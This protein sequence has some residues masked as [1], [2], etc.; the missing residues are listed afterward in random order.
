M[1]DRKNPVYLRLMIIV[2]ALFLG[3]SLNMFQ[4]RNP[5]RNLGM[6]PP[7]SSQ[8][9]EPTK[10]V[11]G[12][13]PQPQGPTE[14]QTLPSASEEGAAPKTAQQAAPGDGATPKPEPA[15]E[16]G[17]ASKSGGESPADQTASPALSAPDD[18]AQAAAP[19]AVQPAVETARDNGLTQPAVTS[20]EKKV[21]SAKLGRQVPADAK[22][23]DAAETANAQAE[24]PAAAQPQPKETAKSAAK[25][26][27]ASGQS[28]QAQFTAPKQADQPAGGGE[29]SAVSAGGKVLDIKVQDNPSEFVLTIVTDAPLERVTSFHA[30]APARL[31]VD[32]W[33]PWQ[34]SGGGA[35][36]VQNGLMEKVRL[37]AHPDKLRVVIDY[38]DKDLATFSEPV[39][40]KQPKG[41]VV[42]VPKPKTAAQ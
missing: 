6:E 11:A 36:T 38:R 27:Q 22:G 29:K 15:R 24:A 37:G 2:V 7:K 25:V 3:L 34:T 12:Q 32:L 23:G 13:E 5:F 4:F 39:I 18:K 9:S 10:F 14:S 41:V 17:Q 33:G 28:V 20:D 26:E 1:A 31:A 40:E 21:R 19:Q 42:R 35:V 30:K 8:P 16:S